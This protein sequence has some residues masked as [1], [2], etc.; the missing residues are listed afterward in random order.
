MAA[1]SSAMR[2]RSLEMRQVAAGEYPFESASSK[3]P[4]LMFVLPMSSAS[5]N[6]GP[7]VCP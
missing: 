6:V 3:T 7:R 5:S 2:L 1:Y 4:I